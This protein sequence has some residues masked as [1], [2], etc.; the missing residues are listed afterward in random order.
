MR[1]QP[2]VRGVILTAFAALACSSGGGPSG[3][4]PDPN[5][6]RTDIGAA[7][8]R[9]CLGTQATVTIPAGA[10]SNTQAI[11]ITAVAM[12]ADLANEGGIG[13]A[14]RYDPIGLTFNVPVRI[15]INVP[16]SAL[17][18]RPLSSVTLRRSTTVQSLSTA[19]VELSD[20]QRS[21][22]GTVSGLTTRLGVFAA[23]IPNGAP[24]ANAGANQSVTA[25]ATVNLAGTGT[26]PDSDQLTF[27]WAFVSRPAGSAATI[28]NPTSANTSFTADVAGTYDVRLT[29]NDGHNHTAT[30]DVQIVA[31]PVGGGNRAPIANAGPDQAGSTGSPV[32]LNGTLS[33]DPDGNQ[34]TFSWSFVSRPA[35]SGASINNGNSATATFTPDLPGVYE[36][37]LTVTDGSL[38][39]QDT[40]IITVGQTNRAPTLSLAATADVVFI[41]TSI[42]ITAATSDPDGD[43][44][45]VD[46]VLV[47]GPSGGFSSSG[48]TANISGSVPGHY[49]VRATASDGRGGTA[50]AE[51]EV[52]VN[53]HVNGSY[54]VTVNADATS[55]GQGNQTANGTL[56]VLQPSPGVVILDLPTASD[57]FA[58][59]AQGTLEGE[60]FFFSGTISIKS[61]SSTFPFTGTINGTMTEGGQLNLQ[62]SFSAPADFCRIN[63]TIVGTRN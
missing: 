51:I 37:R 11:T 59:Q 46:F 48:N 41:G 52:S 28:A 12:P 9:A 54:A 62:F 13:Q 30:D 26:D 63:G 2:L 32:T 15:A 55:C 31:A 50:T 61:G 57:T 43:P 53:P 25:G 22:D 44:V 49:V 56:P 38:A 45:S 18:G 10:L 36:V 1:I 39:S 60:E 23:A 3:P 6:C 29:V 33:S 19:G 20:I 35:G 47:S 58:S 42:Q 27:S 5:A 34:L 4:G 40:V 14:Y 16:A 7:G 8:G 21:S 17:G 24:T